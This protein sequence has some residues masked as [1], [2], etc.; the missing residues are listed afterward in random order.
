MRNEKAKTG[1]TDALEC[2]TGNRHLQPRHDAPGSPIQHNLLS[3]SNQPQK[4]KVDTK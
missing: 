3:A 1:R 2:A 4:P